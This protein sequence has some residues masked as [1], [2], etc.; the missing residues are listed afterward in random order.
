M[1]RIARR[2]P[3]TKPVASLPQSDAIGYLRVS[4][5]EQ[6]RSGL[7]LAAQRTHIEHFAADEGYFIQCWYQ[8]IQTGAGTDALLRR[9]GLAGALKAARARRCPLIVSKL[10]RLSRNVHFIVG[11][12][13]HKVHFMVAAPGRDCDTFTLHIYASLAEQE[14]KMISERATAAAAVAQRRGTK[15]GLARRSKA[16]RRRVSAL[17]RAALVREANERVEAHRAHVEWA[18]RQPGL[19][20]A[21]SFRAA[22]AALNDR[23]IESPTGQ[24]WQGHALQR[25]ARRL[26][27]AHPPG[28]L[29]DDDVHA[30]VQALWRQDPACTPPQVVARFKGDHTLGLQRAGIVLKQVRAAAAKRYPTYR[31]TAGPWIAGPRRGF[32]SQAS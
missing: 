10:D 7:G 1:K 31:R 19:D 15:F 3:Q 21:I 17:G 14:R 23:G 32:A 27:L 25:M 4:T 9:P 29:S 30:R 28:Y 13:E 18:L 11:L 20:G 24:R 6:G 8:D 12:L 5:Q 2:A 22:A 16:V 26:G